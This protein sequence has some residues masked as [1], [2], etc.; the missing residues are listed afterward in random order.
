MSVA[1]GSFTLPNAGITSRKPK[2]KIVVH[3]YDWSDENAVTDMGKGPVRIEVEG[4]VRTLTERDNLEQAL[5]T[6]SEQKLYFASENGED[7]DRYHK[8]FVVEGPTFALT[9]DT[10]QKYTVEFIAVDPQIYVSATDAPA[11]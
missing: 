2:R 6:S 4:F 7:G 5:E 3:E 10:A 8:A 1:F 9:N 11:W